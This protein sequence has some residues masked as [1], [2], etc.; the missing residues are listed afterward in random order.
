MNR[1][2]QVKRQTKETAINL[3]LV[4]DG[5][6]KYT[7]GTGIGFMDHMLTLWTRHGALDLALEL[8]G[9]LEVDVHHT[10]EDLGICLGTALKQALGDKSGIGRYGTAWVP[11]DEALVMVALDLSGRPYLVY[12]VSLQAER[13][14]AMETEVVEEFLRALVNNAGI[15]LH[16]R[17]ISGKN[18]HHTIE[19]IF[20][21]FG[22]ALAEAARLQPGL[23]GVLS[24]KGILQE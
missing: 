6:G 10:V 23:I 15:T 5:L 4:L 14:G 16:V 24:T 18:T 2:G 19:A 9:D 17:M 1:V 21:A 12:D 7:G 20:K 3:E 11:M 8:D 22:R 13:V